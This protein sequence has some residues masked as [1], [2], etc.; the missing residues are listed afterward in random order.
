MN[1]VDS[2]PPHISVK[3]R[4]ERTL[5]LRCSPQKFKISPDPVTM[6][7]ER[8]VIFLFQLS[9]ISARSQVLFDQLL[10]VELPVELRPLSP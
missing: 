1:F 10:L 5:I 2:I 6:S 8:K 3:G 7:S 4:A 9:L